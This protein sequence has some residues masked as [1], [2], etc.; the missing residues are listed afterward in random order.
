[1][2][3]QQIDDFSDLNVDFQDFDLDIRTSEDDH[4]YMEY[5]LE[6][7]GGESPLTWGNKDGELTMKESNGSTGGYFINYDL[8]F[9]KGEMEETE[10]QDILNTVIL[11]VPEKA[12]LSNA[13]LT[14]SNG[15]LTIEK[16]LCKNM[17]AKLDDGDLFAGEFQADEL[18]LKNSDGDVTLKKAALAD[19]K[20]TLG[21]GDLEIDKSS[22][23]GDMKI[24]NSNG[25]VS[26]GTDA[27]SLE[28][29]DIYLETSN[30]SIDTGRISSGSSNSDDDT[31]V[32]ENKVN[33]ADASLEVSSSD[34]DITLTE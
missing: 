27:D 4:Y 9:L 18:Q 5:R 7:I 34:G 12:E 20:I 10:K 24:K 19:G 6:K 15:D 13:K 32:Y 26:I 25:D 1:M 29:T 28:K 22:F 11:Y 30:G 3:K 14:F 33:N 17:T 16:L 2:K 31:A 23:D 8:G 21:D